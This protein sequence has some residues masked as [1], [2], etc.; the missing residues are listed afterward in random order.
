MKFEFLGQVRH[1]GGEPER[2]EDAAEP[3]EGPEAQ[4]G[5]DEGAREAGERGLFVFVFSY[6][7][8]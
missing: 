8:I 4:R 7:V 5:P 2:P 6:L 3:G 1:D